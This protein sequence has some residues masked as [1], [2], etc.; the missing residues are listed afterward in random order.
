MFNQLLCFDDSYDFIM[1]VFYLDLNVPV[2]GI[3][4]SEGSLH[5]YSCD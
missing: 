2:Q 1:M 4:L 5:V 3:G